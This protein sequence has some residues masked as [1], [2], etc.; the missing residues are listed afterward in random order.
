M[1]R[2]RL[3]SS[4]KARAGSEVESVGEACEAVMAVVDAVCDGKAGKAVDVV[5]EVVW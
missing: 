5:G 3:S 4:A 1:F 2:R